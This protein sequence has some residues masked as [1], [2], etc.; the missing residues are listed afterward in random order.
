MPKITIEVARMEL[1]ARR[2]FA[3]TCQLVHREMIAVISESGLFPG[4]PGDIV[5]TGLLRASQQPPRI[6]SNGAGAVARFANN[7]DYAIAVHEGAEF[8]AGESWPVAEHQRRITQAFG[9]PIS[10]K[11]ITVKASVRTRQK[12]RVVEGRPWMRLAL[13]RI[14]IN[15]T[16]ERLI[17]ENL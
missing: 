4:Y 7:A 13:E 15:Q 9:R 17:N 1:A 5:D 2:A 14:D 8:R 10:P 16:F 6:T 11:T 12:G 3:D